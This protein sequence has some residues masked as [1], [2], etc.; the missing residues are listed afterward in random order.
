MINKVKKHLFIFS[1][2][3]NC[4]RCSTDDSTVD[5]IILQTFNV[6]I[7]MQFVRLMLMEATSS[8]R[9]PVTEEASSEN[10]H[11]ITGKTPKLQIL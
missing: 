2:D 10:V 3:L 5:I 1:S 9:N 8:L 7:L 11:P 4:N 6:R